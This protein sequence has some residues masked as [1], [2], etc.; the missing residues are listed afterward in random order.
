MH[1]DTK[2]SRPSFSFEV[3]NT[4]TFPAEARP[5]PAVEAVDLKS[6]QYLFDL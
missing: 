4:L 5:L 3:F 1:G 6:G 2:I